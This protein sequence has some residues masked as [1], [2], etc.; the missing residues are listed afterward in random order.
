MIAILAAVLAL[1]PFRPLPERVA[2]A[3]FVGIVEVK[4][5]YPAPRPDEYR[6]V[7]DA[8]VVETLK[9]DDVPARIAINFDMGAS[10]PNVIFELDD[11]YLVFLARN[12]DGTYTSVSPRRHKIEAGN[13]DHWQGRGL[14]PVDMVK[15]EIV[16][17]LTP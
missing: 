3:D 15:R 9:G 11:S 7:A 8:W 16:S 13:I 10:C 6:Q 17:L 5:S 2:V 14:V 4:S 12:A 1:V